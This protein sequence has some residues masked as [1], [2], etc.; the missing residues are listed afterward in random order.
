MEKIIEQFDKFCISRENQIVERC[1]FHR[2][3]QQPGESVLQYVSALHTLATI[4]K[5][6]VNLDEIIGDG[7]CMRLSETSTVMQFLKHPDLTLEKKKTEIV[8]LEESA[9]TDS[10]WLVRRIRSWRLEAV[11]ADKHHS[12]QSSPGSKGYKN[13]ATSVVSPATQ[14]VSA[15]QLEKPVRSVADTLP[16]SVAVSLYMWKKA[17]INKPRSQTSPSEMHIIPRRSEHEPG[18]I[19]D[20]KAEN[21]IISYHIF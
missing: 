13:R 20:S 5:F 11:V 4:C 7:L 16:Q 14:A 17:P 2:R 6:G 12:Q 9:K 15:L 1:N 19:M 8:A 21:H 10:S 18:F 3:A